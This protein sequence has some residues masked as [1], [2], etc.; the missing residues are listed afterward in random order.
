MGEFPN[1]ATQFSSTYQPKERGRKP[2]ILAE[3]TRLTGE[4]FKIKLSKQQK[5]E[6]IESMLERTKEELEELEKN[7]S[8]PVFLTLAAKAI[9]K[10]IESKSMFTAEMIFDRCFGKPRQAIDNNLSGELDFTVNFDKPYSAPKE[11]QPEVTAPDG[12]NS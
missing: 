1:K 9:L 12:A 7:D 6:L 3:L 5:Y 11:Q 10:D 2:S 4:E 8:I